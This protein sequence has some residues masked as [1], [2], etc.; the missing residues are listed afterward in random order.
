[1][2]DVRWQM[3]DGRWQM[4]DGRWQIAD[5]RWR[6]IEDRACLP[7]PARGERVGVRGTT[8]TLQQPVRKCGSRFPS[9]YPSP[10]DGARETSTDNLLSA[11]AT[12]GR[13]YSRRRARYGSPAA[14]RDWPRPCGEGERS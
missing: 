2:S 4:A 13:T 10:H 1:M 11:A 12:A 7:R 6:T 3:A 9:P 8:T 5:R 14:R